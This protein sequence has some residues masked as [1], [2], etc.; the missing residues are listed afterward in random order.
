MNT[1][2]HAVKGILIP[3]LIIFTLMAALVLVSTTFAAEKAATD[4][5]GWI[6]VKKAVEWNGA[7]PDTGKVFEICVTKLPDTDMGCQEFTYQDV[8]D[9]TEK[10]WYFSSTGTYVVWE[11]DPGIEWEWTVSGGSEIV[12]IPGDI[13]YHKTVTNT[14]RSLDYG[15]LPDA[16]GLTLLSEGGPSHEIGVLF[17]GGPPDGGI[18]TEFDGQPDPDALGDTKDDGV[19]PQGNWSNPSNGTLKVNVTGGPGCLFGWLDYT[20]GTEG[21]GGSFTTD[22][23]LLYN[24]PVTV[25]ENIIPINTFEPEIDYDAIQ[26]ALTYARF[27][28]L[29]Q[30]TGGICDYGGASD[31]LDMLTGAY[32]DG[33]V[34]DYYWPF[35]TNAVSMAGFSA[36]SQQTPV[37]VIAGLALLTLV[38]LTT[39]A[40]R[41]WCMVTP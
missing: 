41:R 33:E 26:G 9:E 40:W 11:E 14:T 22:E 13:S 2:K 35:G 31:K 8:L 24:K 16:Y 10:G 27:R 6:Y 4:T 12:V 29:P 5:Y 15:D 7:T 34:E 30:Q 21:F 32:I 28:L 19:V 23:V 1:K 25:G 20:G 36:S 3:L 38:A 18:T 39:L 37:L 17:L